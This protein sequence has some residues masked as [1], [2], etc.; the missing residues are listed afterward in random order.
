MYKDLPYKDIFR[1]L[2]ANSCQFR[3]NSDDLFLQS[4]MVDGYNG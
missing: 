1:C 4:L 3:C 2:E